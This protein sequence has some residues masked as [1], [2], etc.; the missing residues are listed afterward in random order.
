MV[1][2]TT[3]AI[4][5]LG[6]TSF[7]EE[8][9][10]SGVAEE[11]RTVVTEQIH[12]EGPAFTDLRKI[13]DDTTQSEENRIAAIQKIGEDGSP[14]AI[15]YLLRHI[16]LT[17]PSVLVRTDTDRFRFEP[18]IYAL[19]KHGERVIPHVLRFIETLREEEDLKQIARLFRITGQN[20]AARKT[21]SEKREQSKTD[22]LSEA[23]LKNI[24]QLL[25]HLPEPRK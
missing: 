18:C 5:F 6:G 8:R 25:L 11:C 23:M 4:V 13:A 24:D 22:P 2:I 17:M 9:E 3:C 21:L 7:C 1:T 15:D 19:A 14:G 10:R 16:C 20:T 12:G